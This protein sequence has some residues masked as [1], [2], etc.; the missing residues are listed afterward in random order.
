MGLLA[1]LALFRNG[2]EKAVFHN[3]THKILFHFM[4]KNENIKI[5]KVTN[6]KS[7]HTLCT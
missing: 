4:S 2:R 6:A 5:A 7:L 3:I 1:K